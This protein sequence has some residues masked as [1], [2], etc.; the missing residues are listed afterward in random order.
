MQQVSNRQNTIHLGLRID[1]ELCRRH[2][3]GMIAWQ[4]RLAKQTLQSN[5]ATAS[6]C[7]TSS[8]DAQ[9]KATQNWVAY[10][11]GSWRI[12]TAD[13][14]LVRQMLWTSWAK[15]PIVKAW[16]CKG[17]HYFLICKLFD[18]FFKSLVIFSEARPH[19]LLIVVTISFS[20]YWS[21]PLQIRLPP[22]CATHALSAWTRTWT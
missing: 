6:R 5:K 15:L 20:N 18:K 12:R 22:F 4:A 3:F 16:D 7:S 17:N 21:L 1:V 2:W 8:M 10:G 14:L 19:R 13:P 9:K 11:S